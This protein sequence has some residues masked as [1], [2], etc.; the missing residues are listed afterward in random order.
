M[1]WISGPDLDLTD[2]DPRDVVGALLRA[3]G[4]H[5][6]AGVVVVEE[7]ERKLITY[8]QLLERAG[9][10]LTGLRARG[11]RQGDHVVLAGLALAD[12]FPAFWACALGGMTPATVAELADKGS[13][14]MERLRHTWRLLG[15]TTTS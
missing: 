1:T 4:S 2:D 11:V 7:G 8:P 14:A 3:A 13:P 15:M 6:D 9:R 12:F 5:S 10:I